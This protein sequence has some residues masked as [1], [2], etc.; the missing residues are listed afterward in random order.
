MSITRRSMIAA[1]PAMGMAPIVP[2][3][4][5]PV[6]TLPDRVMRLAKELSL[7]LDEMNADAYEIDYGADEVG[8]WI[9]E[10]WPRRIN[11]HVC[12]AQKDIPAS[13]VRFSKERRS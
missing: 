3:M 2:A 4:A 11:P 7:A 9:A 12:L 8:I 5:G 6:E 10:V 13:L 1:I